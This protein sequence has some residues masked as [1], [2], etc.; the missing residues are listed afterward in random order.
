S[1]V[2]GSAMHRRAFLLHTALATC[3]SSVR[4]IGRAVPALAESRR[5]P[6]LAIGLGPQLV[7][8]DFFIEQLDGLKLQV[9]SPQRLP[10][11]VLD[12]KT[13]GTTQPY[14][15]VLRD[16]ETKRLRIWYNRGP[17]VWHAESQDGVLWTNPRVAWDL[18]RGY[19]CSIID[20]GLDAPDPQRRFKF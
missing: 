6:P 16:A 9:Q 7:P 10:K 18:P 1:L 13:F 15:T 8:D 17:A 19:G 4:E 3:A 11:H 14:L 12:S 2:T 20:D 5:S